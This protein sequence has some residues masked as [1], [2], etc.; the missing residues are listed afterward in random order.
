[1]TQA[2][3]GGVQLPRADAGA[4]L[5]LELRHLRYFVAL[6]E[7]GSFTHAAERIFIAQPTLSQQIRRLE[8]IIARRCCSAAV[9]GCG[10]PQRAQFCL[11]PPGMCCP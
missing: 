10:S 8:E 7:A 2:Q 3:A 1:M 4:P 5:G 11:T 9:R 6:A